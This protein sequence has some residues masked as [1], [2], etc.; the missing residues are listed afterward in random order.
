MFTRLRTLFSDPVTPPNSSPELLLV[1]I[2][3]AG[4]PEPVTKEIRESILSLQYHPGFQS[5]I[6]K[7]R[8]QRAVIDARL[9]SERHQDLKD[10]YLL[11][12]MISGFNWLDQQIDQ[13]VQVGKSAQRLPATPYEQQLFEQ[14][15]AAIE[16]I[17]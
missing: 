14:A 13:E 4:R 5:L 9:R 6:R 12:S 15:N 16:R 2:P 3:E 7:L 1:Q 17:E 11:Q 10:V 8:F